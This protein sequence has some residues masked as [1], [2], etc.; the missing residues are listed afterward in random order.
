[1]VGKIRQAIFVSKKGRWQCRG[2]KTSL[3]P[4]DSIATRREARDTAITKKIPLSRAKRGVLCRD[5]EKR[6]I[7]DLPCA[8]K[9]TSRA[10]RGGYKEVRHEVRCT[11]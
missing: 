10:A 8:G 5:V 6:T 1:M 2:A 9:K 3:K 7:C 11:G 4:D